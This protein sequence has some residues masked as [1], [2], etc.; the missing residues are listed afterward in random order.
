M[1]ERIA[2][3]FQIGG[4]LTR[5]QAEELVEIANAEYYLGVD[6]GEGPLTIDDVGKLWASSEINYGNLDDLIGYC[7][8]NKID[9]EYWYDH[10]SEWDAHKMRV[11]GGELIEFCSGNSGDY[12]LLDDLVKLDALATGW[13]ALHEKIRKWREPFP[14]VE[15]VDG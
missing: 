7:Q 14:K 1:G 15:I 11:V 13:A 12:I 2:A 4:K 9:Y 10:G 6:Y 5:S 3:S 8:V